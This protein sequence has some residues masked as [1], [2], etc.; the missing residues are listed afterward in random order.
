MSIPTITLTN[1]VQMPALG[2]RVFQTPP[3]ETIAAVRTALEAAAHSDTAAAYGNEREVGCGDRPLR[4]RADGVFVETKV[5]I[6]DYGYD[7]TLHAFDKSAGKL[8]LPWSSPSSS[9]SP[10]AGPSGHRRRGR[11]R[12]VTTARAAGP[13][14][15]A[16][17]RSTGT[18]SVAG[19]RLAWR[20]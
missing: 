18:P 6:S 10:P 15:L 2:L 20:S 17:P 19:P 8:G 12:G 7:Q 14:A 13:G 3:D 16:V 5:S 4:R 11:V 9:S 1:G